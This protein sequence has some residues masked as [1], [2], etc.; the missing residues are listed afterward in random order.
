MTTATRPDPRPAAARRPWPL[1]ASWL[2]YWIVV[3][4]IGVGPGLAAAW[5]AGHLPEENS[6]TVSFGAGSEGLSLLVQEY[7]RTTWEGAV[8]PL[9]LGL[10]IV[11]GPLV[12]TA[13][14]TL[15]GRRRR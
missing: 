8:G 6:G 2:L 15:V 13:I 7:G 9:A 12:L 5:R 10:W 4:A 1:L 11:G 3:L 14:W